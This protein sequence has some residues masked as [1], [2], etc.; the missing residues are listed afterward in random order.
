MDDYI[1]LCEECSDECYVASYSPPEFCPMCGE[2]CNHE[3]VRDELDNNEE[4]DD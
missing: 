4:F 3:I 1:V 2:Q